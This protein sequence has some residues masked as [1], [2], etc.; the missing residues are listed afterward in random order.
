M[1]VTKEIN[2]EMCGTAWVNKEDPRISDRAES[3]EGACQADEEWLS[4]WKEVEIQRCRCKK[5]LDGL[6]NAGNHVRISQRE[7]FRGPEAH[8]PKGL[9]KGGGVGLYLLNFVGFATCSLCMIVPPY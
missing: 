2:G 8:I 4:R 6:K 1:D 3:E 7:G 9:Y 5:G